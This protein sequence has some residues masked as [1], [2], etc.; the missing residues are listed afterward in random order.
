MISIRS[1]SSISTAIDTS[2]RPRYNLRLDQGSREVTEYLDLLL[3][4]GRSRN[5]GNGRRLH[6]RIVATGHQD[7]MFLANHILIMYGK[8]GGMEDLSRAFSEMKR[9]NIVSW[10]AVISAYAQNDRSSD[11]IVIFLRMLLDGIQP[12]YVTFTSVLNAF[13]GPELHRWAKLVH[14]LALEVGFGSHPVVAT[15]LLNMYSKVGSIDRARQVFD[16]LAIKDVVSWSNMIAAYAQTGHG[17]EALEMFHRMDAEGIQ[18]N[19]ITFVAVVHACVLVARITDART[20]HRRIIEAG[21][22]SNTVL[23]TALLNMYGKCGGLPEAKKIFDK[24][25][26]RDVV[27]WSAILEAY[28]RH[29][30]PRVALKL[31]TLMQQ[32]GV[33]PNDVTFVGVLEACCHGGFVPEGR[34]HFASL[35]RDHE[36]RPTAHHVHC[37]LDM[38]GRAG[39]LEEAESFIARMPVKEEAITWSIFLG[40]CRSYGDLE[41][42]KRAAEK[43]FEFLP[44]CRAGYLT[45]ASMY[46]DAGMPEEAEAVARLME[47]RCPKKEPG[48]SKIVVRGR[49]HEFCVRSQWHPQAKEI[50]SYLDVLHARALEL[51]YVPDTRP[52]LL[53]SVERKLHSERLALAFGAMSVPG[54]RNSP[55]H[56]I[57][58]LRVCR[59]CHEFTKF[60]SRTM[61]GREIIVRDTSRFHLFKDGVCSC[62]DYW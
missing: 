23:G 26:E 51:G 42:G 27:V 28:A 13:A 15:A 33:R 1:S 41:R 55:I 19:V 60:V 50:Y 53:G 21:L 22:E 54:K 61:E 44:H 5:L 35:V 36:L 24:L 62:G 34:F 45:L 56:I 7:V 8:C 29:G 17:T 32:E 31:F 57:K 59:D 49:V 6:A 43:V 18:A 38:L 30:H 20:I 25:T 46:T 16:E 47:S 4:C 48:S 12:S 37:M 11:A 3:A 9:R 58:N 52:L 40:S 10:N 14:D 39:K 2:R